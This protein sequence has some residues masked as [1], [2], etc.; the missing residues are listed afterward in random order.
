MHP[1]LPASRPRPAAVDGAGAARWGPV[2]ALAGLHGAVTLAWVVYT[3]YLVALL[4]RA[5]F[6]AYL[7]SVLLT[8][9]GLRGG[10]P[11][12]ARGHALRPGPQRALPPVLPGDGGSAGHHASSSWR[13]R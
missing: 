1:A 9:E 13:C 11:R 3:L 8:V 12:A 2:L 7:A 10:G 4:A 6:D 5:G